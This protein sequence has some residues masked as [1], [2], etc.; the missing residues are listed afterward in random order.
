MPEYPTCK[1]YIEDWHRL[2]KW[3]PKNTIVRFV[4]KKYCYADLSKKLELQNIDKV[5]LGFL[6][7]SLFFSENFTT[8]IRY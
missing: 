8:Y 2:V 7:A 5:K 4:N 3:N 1:K 6:E